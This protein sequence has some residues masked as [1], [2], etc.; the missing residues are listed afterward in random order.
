MGI[1]DASGQAVCWF[2][3]CFQ[4]SKGYVWE[5]EKGKRVKDP[6]SHDG[7]TA[8]KQRNDVVR[9]ILALLTAK[10]QNVKTDKIL[11]LL[12]E[13]KVALD[14]GN[15]A[16]DKGRLQEASIYWKSA[17]VYSEELCQELIDNIH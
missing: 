7:M 6:D 2:S 12:R 5:P 14:K 8:Y 3:E 11:G 17:Q 13:W 9:A 4:P 16:R 15:D 10:A 1:M